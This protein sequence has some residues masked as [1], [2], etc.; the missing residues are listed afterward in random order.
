MLSKKIEMHKYDINSQ[1]EEETMKS[2]IY[3]IFLAMTALSAGA[4]AVKPVP[5]QETGLPVTG[6]T[7]GG[8]GVYTGVDGTNFI[9]KT[10][11]PN[12]WIFTPCTTISNKGSTIVNLEAR[13][14]EG[15][16]EPY[17]TTHPPGSTETVCFE[18]DEQ[19]P[20]ALL[21]HCQDGAAGCLVFWRLDSYR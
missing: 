21:L 4:L 16:R 17:Y 18:D 14:P 5:E 8:P 20:V 10:V 1:D 19:P 12:S 3:L 9:F 13:Y 6:R 7:V 15:D 11:P 2:I